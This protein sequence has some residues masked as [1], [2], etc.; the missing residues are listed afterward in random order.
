MH[1]NNC[2]HAGLCT[3]TQLF[4]HAHKAHNCLQHASHY[5]TGMLNRA[6]TSRGTV[7]AHAAS[8]LSSSHKAKNSSMTH[9]TCSACSCSSAPPRSSCCRRRGLPT[10]LP[11]SRPCRAGRSAP[12]AARCCAA[13]CLHGRRWIGVKWSELDGQRQHHV[14][15]CGQWQLLEMDEAFEQKM[16]TQQLWVPAVQLCGLQNCW[17]QQISI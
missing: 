12:P 9:L 11:R 17:T 2:T 1:L 3:L 6:R 8:P 13:T 7:R 4:K 5:I 14:R 16:Y 15:M 10:A